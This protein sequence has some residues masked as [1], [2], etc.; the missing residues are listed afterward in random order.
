MPTENTPEQNLMSLKS[1]IGRGSGGYAT[2][3]PQYVGSWND[4]VQQL[5]KMLG[6][7]PESIL[8]LNSW[9]KDNKFKANNSEYTVIKLSGQTAS[10]TDSNGTSNNTPTG[11]YTSDGW[12]HPLGVGTWYCQQAYKSTHKAIDFTT[13]TPGRIAGSPIYASK[14]GTVVSIRRDDDGEHGGG[15]GNA[16][17]IRHDDTMVG[18]NCYYTRYA[19]MVSPPSFKTGDKVSQGDKLGAVGNTGKSTG[20][21][22][23]FQIYFTSATR[24]DYGTFTATADFSVNP[25]S[26]SDFPGTPYTEGQSFSVN[27]TK[28]PYITDDDINVIAG[29]ADGDGS[30]TQSQ[31]DETVN[32]IISRVQNGLGVQPTSKHGQ[33]ISEFISAQ[34]NGIKDQG[35]EAVLQLLQGG[36]FYT[37]FDNFCNSVVF[38]AVYYVTDK[39]GQAIVGATT[40]FKNSAKTNL[41]NWVFS[42]T[43][44]DPNSSTANALGGY[45]DQYVDIIAQNGW[46]AVKT[47]ISQDD[48]SKAC[49]IFITESY[50]DSIDFMCSVTA[51]GTATAIASYIPTVISDTNT[52]N[53][54]MSLSTGIMNV[55]IQSCGGVLKGD[56]SI[57]QAAKNILSQGV[58]SI[59]TTV[60]QQY[61]RPFIVDT[62][63]DYAKD[64]VVALCTA[65]GL[66]IGGPLGALIGGLIGAVVSSIIDSLFNLLLGKMTGFFNQ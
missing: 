56:I 13:G 14:A 11:Y 31:F 36:N 49:E 19:H 35:K 46:D 32:G 48:V 30:V 23:H 50:R 54:V 65:A 53:V 20:Y 22:L 6:I 21:H 38:N 60:Y 16:V 55:I 40:E 45:L 33:I 57:E 2:I 8:N 18:G 24:T 34:L 27:Y 47:A 25:N 44:L 52:A 43:N 64:G 59:T 17:L 5:S 58:I 15:W 3:K 12:V 4:D 29:A 63:T 51:H 26:V 66:D 7:A 41:K 28:S 9:L 62:I 10:S 42:A 1:N 61:V 39:I 37:V